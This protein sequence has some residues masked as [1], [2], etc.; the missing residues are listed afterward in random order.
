[1]EVRLSGGDR[2]QRPGNSDLSLDHEKEEV[3]VI[4]FLKERRNQPEKVLKQPGRKVSATVFQGDLPAVLQGVQKVL[5]H[6]LDCTAPAHPDAA[7]EV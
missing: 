6:L 4:P 1:M 2:G 5:F 3:L 7:L